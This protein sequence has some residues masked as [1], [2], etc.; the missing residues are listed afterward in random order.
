MSFE[1]LEG[2]NITE[3]NFN[4]LSSMDY[5]T[6]ILNI[7]MFVFA[8]KLITKTDD[9]GRMNGNYDKKVTVLRFINIIL[10]FVYISCFILNKP[11][12][13]GWSQSSLLLIASFLVS[14]YL[15]HFL[16]LKYGDHETVDEV[17]L[18]TDNYLTRISRLFTGFTITILVGFGLIYIWDLKDWLQNGG[19]LVMLGLLLF[20]TKEFWL[21]NVLSSFSINAKGLLKRGAVIK[22]DD[23]RDVWVI[24]ETTFINTWLKNMK[25]DVHKSVPN[26]DLINKP[27]ELLSL[28]VDN[29]QVVEKGKKTKKEYK[30]ISHDIIFN[31]GY[32]SS[33]EEVKFFF[34]KV[35][36]KAS[37][38]CNSLNSNYLLN[39]HSNG[40]HAISWEIVYSINNPFQFH[41]A[42]NLI[43]L[44]A[45]QKQ[46]ECM[47]DLST[48]ITHKRI[49]NTVSFIED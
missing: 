34:D 16:L 12:G 8:K 28:S 3:E 49:E 5:F 37:K 33:Y 18:H 40:D 31:I 38:E 7:V 17:I 39:C 26:S 29:K 30:H 6:L 10:F 27:V 14:H 9:F 2:I 35:M 22:I 21:I 36:E 46:R 25:T 43:N 19:I 15:N 42:R 24:L 45:F 44:I 11:F 1:W 4:I 48:P 41:N 20:S 32:D 47:I 13:S 23:S